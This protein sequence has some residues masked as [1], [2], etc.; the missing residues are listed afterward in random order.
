MAE[1]K[2]NDPGIVILLEQVTALVRSEGRW[3]EKR[4]RVLRVATDEDMRALTEFASWFE[5]ESDGH[6]RY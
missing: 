1:R 2:E 6:I 3:Y 5:R 4:N